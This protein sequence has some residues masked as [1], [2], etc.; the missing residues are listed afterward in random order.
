MRLLYFA[1]LRE[2]IG[3]AE[4]ELAPPPGTDWE[5]L[6]STDDPQYGGPGTAPLDTKDW[7]IAGH[8]ALV[9]RPRIEAA[10]PTET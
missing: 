7:H 2:R 10:H 3:T 4:E 1:W 6:F 9:L 8:A 5:I